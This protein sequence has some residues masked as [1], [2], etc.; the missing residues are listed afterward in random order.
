MSKFLADSLR[1]SE[2][3]VPRSRAALWRMSRSSRVARNPTMVV[4]G[5]LF[6]ESVSGSIG[7]SSVNKI[8]YEASFAVLLEVA[9]LAKIKFTNRNLRSQS[10]TN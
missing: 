10:Y 8:K 2:I 3:V 4:L 9:I 5:L 7:F 1:Y 6:S